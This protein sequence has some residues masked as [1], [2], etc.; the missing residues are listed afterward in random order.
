MTEEKA[1]LTKK[2]AELE[3]SLMVEPLRSGRIGRGREN[4]VLW[5]ELN[6]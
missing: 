6:V 4:I 1:T 3:V 5:S 2:I